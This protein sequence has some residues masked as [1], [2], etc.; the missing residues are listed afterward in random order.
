MRTLRLFSI[1]ATTVLIGLLAAP[2][3]AQKVGVS[4]LQ[5]LKVM[6][7]ARATAMGEAYVATARGVDAAFWNPAGLSAIT[8]HEITSTYTL[9]LFD[10]KQAALAYGL[11]L[12]N[13]GQFAVQFQMTD[14][15]AIR[16]TST[17][18]LGY[19]ANGG[20]RD[21]FTG[22]TFTPSSWLVGLSYGRQLTDHFSVGVTAKYVTESLWNGSSITVA[23]IYGTPETFQTSV[24]A[25]LFDVG[26]AYET[27]YRTIRIGAAVQNFG[28]QIRFA[29]EDYPAP[30]MFRLGLAADMIGTD[31]IVAESAENR[32]TIEGDILQPNDYDQ[33]LHFGVEYGFADAL[34]LRA[35]YKWNYDADGLTFGG[36][37]RVTVAGTRLGVDYSFGSMGEYLT[38][39]HRITLGVN[40]Q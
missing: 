1:I 33:Q 8:S 31:A 6:P 15:G 5:F 37:A 26:M 23:N 12:G 36:G 2:A 39:V 28:E 17:D 9:W 38:N 21:G 32:L 24:G 35:G 20:Y 13:W 10:T 11:S 34:F 3:T 30:L 16:E 29:Q 4:S 40:F 25:L 27:G 14:I 7:T 18:L 22:R 19:D